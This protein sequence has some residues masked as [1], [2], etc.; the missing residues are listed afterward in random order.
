MA[1]SLSHGEGRGSTYYIANA[2]LLPDFW[3]Q[4]SQ[5]CIGEEQY[6]KKLPSICA[7]QLRPL[8]E[9]ANFGLQVKST[10]HL[11]LFYDLQAKNGFYI[12]KGS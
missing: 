9:V 1:S 3:K 12:F 7:S 5:P 8:T 2:F 10:Q 11:V 4:T 6:T